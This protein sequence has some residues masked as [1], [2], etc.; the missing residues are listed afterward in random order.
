LQE[1]EKEDELAAAADDAHFH[2]VSFNLHGKEKKYT[3]PLL[4]SVN[5][6]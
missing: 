2:V 5:K 1:G 3:K 4:L 6:I